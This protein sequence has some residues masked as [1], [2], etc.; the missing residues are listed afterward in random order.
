MTD[1]KTLSPQ[2][3]LEK[4]A[5]DLAC[6]RREL[7]AVAAYKDH[8]L[9]EFFVQL[10]AASEEIAP[11][12]VTE[13]YILK[14]RDLHAH[15]TEYAVHSPLGGYN[16]GPLAALSRQQFEILDKKVDRQLQEFLASIG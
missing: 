9:E 7:A 5:S 14:Q 2:E 1:I 11:E 8:S 4:V 3:A 13:D 10:I 12:Q 16:G 15:A 6:A